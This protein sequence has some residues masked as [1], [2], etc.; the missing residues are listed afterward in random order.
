MYFVVSP[1]F[2][3]ECRFPASNTIFKDFDMYSIQFIVTA[4][5]GMTMLSISTKLMAMKTFIRSKMRKLIG[6]HYTINFSLVPVMLSVVAWWI[7]LFAFA[8]PLGFVIANKAL[9]GKAGAPKTM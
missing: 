7:F 4:V 6:L 2:I 5:L 1:V 8:P 9:H 3:G